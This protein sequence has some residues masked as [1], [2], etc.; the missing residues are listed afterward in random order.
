MKTHHFDGK[1]FKSTYYHSSHLRPT[2]TNARQN[3]QLGIVLRR[4]SIWS[5]AAAMS[6]YFHLESLS[7]SLA[8][9]VPD[10]ALYE[11]KQVFYKIDSSHTHTQ[12][13]V[14]A[15]MHMYART[16]TPDV[17]ETLTHICI[18]TACCGKTHQSPIHS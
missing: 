4:K 11:H 5:L 8:L 9:S 15:N 1:K 13:H 12:A 16:Q 17:P 2:P 7:L 6:F 10:S 18:C 3:S 14:H